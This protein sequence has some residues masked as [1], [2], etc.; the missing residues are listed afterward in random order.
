LISSEF[1]KRWYGNYDFKGRLHFIREP[2][3][4]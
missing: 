2:G 1:L 3:K 4:I